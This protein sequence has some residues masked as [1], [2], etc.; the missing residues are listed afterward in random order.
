MLNSVCICVNSEGNNH[1]LNETILTPSSNEA[2]S[3]PSSNEAKSTHS[4]NEAKSTH[5]SNKT[6]YA[7]L[8]HKQ[9]NR[10]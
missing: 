1:F 7:L 4:S 6:I 5:S 3:T 10:G 2:K 8:Y 9:T